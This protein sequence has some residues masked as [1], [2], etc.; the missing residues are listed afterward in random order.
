MPTKTISSTSTSTSTCQYGHGVSGGGRVEIQL[1]SKLVVHKLSS[2]KHAPVNIFKVIPLVDGKRVA[3]QNLHGG[4]ANA[5]PGC[6]ADVQDPCQLAVDIL[7]NTPENV[8]AS[9]IGREG[10]RGEGKR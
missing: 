6:C 2:L 1:P 10:W 5:C 9:R 4:L 3:K 8:P 7:L